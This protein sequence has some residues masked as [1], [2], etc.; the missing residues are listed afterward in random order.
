MVE[1]GHD[2]IVACGSPE[3]RKAQTITMGK[4]G[5]LSYKTTSDLLT[6][7]IYEGINDL[8]FYLKLARKC[9]IMYIL[10]GMGTQAPSH[11]SSES[12]D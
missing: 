2:V 8:Y 3:K 6:K 11:P 12:K 7:E 4:D 10:S 9:D 5:I 1:K